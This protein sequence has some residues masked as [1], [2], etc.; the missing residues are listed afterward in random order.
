MPDALSET[1]PACIDGAEA[2]CHRLM[3]EAKVRIAIE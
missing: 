2:P 1:V 3:D